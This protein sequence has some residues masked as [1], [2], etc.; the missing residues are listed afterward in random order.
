MIRCL[1]IPHQDIT[2]AGS[3]MQRASAS[4]TGEATSQRKGYCRLSRESVVSAIS[5]DFLCDL[6]GEKRI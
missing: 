5:A 1:A 3:Q 2:E 4:E 6:G